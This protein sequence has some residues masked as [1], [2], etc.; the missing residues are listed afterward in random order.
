M[1]QALLRFT[2]QARW[3]RY[4]RKRLRHLFPYLPQQPGYSKRLRKL[5]GVM[6]WLIIRRWVSVKRHQ[7]PERVQNDPAAV[8]R[9]HG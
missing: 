7:A 3:L 1:L 9:R 8:R 6:R 5:A 2:S 4:A